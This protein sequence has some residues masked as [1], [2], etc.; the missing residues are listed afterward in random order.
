LFEDHKKVNLFNYDKYNIDKDIFL[1]VFISIIKKQNFNKL[2]IRDVDSVINFY[3]FSYERNNDLIEEKNFKNFKSDNIN[4]R[5][6]NLKKVNVNNLQHP[7]LPDPDL[8]KT[9]NVLKV[10]NYMIDD[11]NIE[12]GILLLNG[13]FDFFNKKYNTT[14]KYT[15]F[16]DDCFIFHSNCIFK[17]DNNN[18][19]QVTAY[20]NLYLQYYINCYHDSC[21]VE[22][23]YKLIETAINNNLYCELIEQ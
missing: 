9:E 21:K 1:N 19:K 18:N 8:L 4:K 11:N 16:V 14:F 6:Y 7:I 5:P 23:K 12:K 3:K 13:V 2:N 10:N 20:I 17:N 15:E 22:R